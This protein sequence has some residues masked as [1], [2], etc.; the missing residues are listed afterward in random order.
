MIFLLLSQKNKPENK[1]VKVKKKDAEEESEEEEDSEDESDDD[2]D[3][4][5][6]ESEEDESEEDESD[7]DDDDEEDESDEEDEITTSLTA[8]K[9]VRFE[10]VL[11]LIFEVFLILDAIKSLYIPLTNRVR[12]LYQ[13]LQ[14]K[15]FPL[16]FMAQVLCAAGHKS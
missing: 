16:W 9:Q 4:E 7:E 2:D 1:D 10:G 13:K 12:G 11:Q 8:K 14:T 5:G 3:E 15:F 6:E